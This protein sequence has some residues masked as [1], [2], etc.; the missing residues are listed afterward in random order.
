M[1]ICPR[2]KRILRAATIGEASV[3]V[4]GKC[5]GTFF[6]SEDLIGAA[7][8]AA[9][10]STWDRAETGGG[11]KPSEL[12][13]PECETTMD[14]QDVARDGKKVEI[15]RCGKCRGI[16]LDKGE[17]DTLAAIG[18]ALLPMVDAAR[19]KAKK[20]L[21]ELDKHGVDFRQATPIE[22]RRRRA[23]IA[24]VALAA[25]GIGWC[26]YESRKPEPS[27]VPP[28]GGWARKKGEEGCPCGC[29]RSKAMAAEMR[30]KDDAVALTAIDDALVTIA[31]RE[32]AGYV[33]ERMVQHRLRLLDV[34]DEI[35]DRQAT[36][37]GAFGEIERLASDRMMS[38]SRCVSPRRDGGGL[39]VCPELAVHGERIERVKGEEKVI[40]SSFRLWLE[41][42]NRS[43]E[44][45]ALP[46]PVITSKTAELPVSRWYRDGSAGRPWDGRI[47]A[48]ETVRV[49]VIGDIPNH[50]APGT[51]V[52]ALATV[53][54]VEMHL[55]TEARAVIHFS[56]R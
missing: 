43:G 8:I 55:T 16:W 10:P 5:E 56:D 21:E 51:L 25:A 26:N 44:G 54:A 7:G 11:V 27:E 42:E 22:R 52:E 2:D 32:N 29:D 23:S 53:D 50:L 38:V 19:A 34:A 14:A 15:D 4:C 45:R 36:R 30:A 41:I 31:K 48:R 6:D 24:L 9:D 33:T 37:I 3:D 13:C 12:A 35:L 47:A 49:N 17:L 28:P 1:R 40:G 20:E 46:A 39:R 18:G